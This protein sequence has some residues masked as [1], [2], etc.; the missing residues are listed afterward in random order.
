MFKSCPT[1]IRRKRH[2]HPPPLP[3]AKG[4]IDVSRR[5][6]R[7]VRLPLCQQQNKLS[8]FLACRFCKTR[9]VNILLKKI[10]VI[11]EWWLKS[12]ITLTNRILAW[13]AQSQWGHA[14][15]IHLQAT[16][17]R[18]T[19]EQL[20]GRLERILLNHLAGLSVAKVNQNWMFTL[21]LA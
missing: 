4:R 5:R 10:G 16:I 9:K 20:S 6:K 3:T 17:V 7:Y 15:S 11:E 14:H 8:M 1:L 12:I 13:T 21:Q 2:G 19:Q 18:T